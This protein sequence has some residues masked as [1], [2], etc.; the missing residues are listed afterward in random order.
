MDNLH[1]LAEDLIKCFPDEYP[2]VSLTEK[3][4]AFRAGQI[5]IIRR[6]KTALQPAFDL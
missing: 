6:L 5:D 3:E 2:S 4:F 1:L